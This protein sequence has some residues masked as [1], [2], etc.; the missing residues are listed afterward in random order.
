MSVSLCTET[1]YQRYS[2]EELQDDEEERNA[3]EHQI[4][5]QTNQ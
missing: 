5:P 3:V 2:G 1:Q 4:H